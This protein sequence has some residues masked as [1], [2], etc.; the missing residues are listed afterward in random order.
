MRLTLIPRRAV[1]RKRLGACRP[2]LALPAAPTSS[3]VGAGAHPG[4]YA[5]EGARGQVI[6]IFAGAVFLFVLMVAMVADVS[7]FWVNSLMVQRAADAAALAGVVQLTPDSTTAAVT[8]ARAVATMD[9]YTNGTGGVA[10]TV[11]RD[12]NWDHRLDVAVTTTIPTFFLH[13]LGINSLPITRTGVADYTTPVPMGSPENAYGVYGPVRTT[14][15]GTNQVLPANTGAKVATTTPTDLW[16]ST[17]TT[18]TTRVNSLNTVNAQ[19]ATTSTTARA[20]TLGSFGFTFPASPTITG[21]TVGLI[22]S[23]TGATPANCS[24]SVD[25]SWNNG[26]S[27]TTVAGTGVKTQALTAADATY[28]LGGTA[29]KWGRGTWT[30]TELGNAA[31]LVRATSVIGSGC[32]AI[33]I[34]QVTARVDY[35]ALTF[36]P[37]P[38]LQGPQGQTLTTRGFWG[39]SLSQGAETINGDAYLP[40]WDTINGTQNS[41]YNQ[42]QFYNYVDD[43]PANVSGRLYIYDPGFCEGTLTTGVGDT[44]AATSYQAVD[45]YFDLFEDPNDTPYDES[46]DNLL[47]SS[48]VNNLFLNSTGSDPS[49]GGNNGSGING[50]DAYHLAWYEIPVTLAGGAHGQKFRLHVYSA[51]PNNASDQRNTNARNGWALYTTVPGGRIYGLG[52]MEIFTPLPGGQSSTFYLAQ[53]AAAHAGRIVEINLFDPGDT[54]QNANIQILVPSSS[55]WAAATFKWTSR[56]GTTN[57]GHSTCTQSTPL[58]ATSLITYASSASKF[59]GCWVTM[60]VPVAANYTA[61]QD[62]WWKIQYNMTGATGTTATD[63]TT[64]QVNILGSPAH[65]VVP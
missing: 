50:C 52:A 42:P 65:L 4:A 48:S 33:K 64:W 17:P 25:L 8:A 3:A 11:V 43:V 59:N 18:T 62:G 12:P 45:A 5:M 54:N 57:T 27:W 24:V 29:D 19:Y 41:K 31:F 34:D 14:A 53:I 7:W 58:S 16:T 44:W 2:N 22:A 40:Q 63:I 28:T 9:G 6:V 47:W 37:D 10:V 1:A 60:T 32:T 51:N 13:M 30:T 21:L 49:L 23:A 15:G 38:N 26:T 56:A 55:G 35:T 36:V 61:P 20:E 39:A 46:D